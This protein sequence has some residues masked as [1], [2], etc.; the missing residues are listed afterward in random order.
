MEELGDL[1]NEKISDQETII[2][3]QTK[4]IEKQEERLE[5]V[6]RNGSDG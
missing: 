2:N 1:K 4:V 5:S 6:W 3:L